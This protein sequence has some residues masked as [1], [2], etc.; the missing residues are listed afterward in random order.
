MNRGDVAA[1]TPIMLLVV[2]ALLDVSPRPNGWGP[3]W[4]VER[5]E[6]SPGGPGR[7]QAPARF[8][9]GAA[10]FAGNGTVAPSVSPA[11]EQKYLSLIHGRHDRAKAALDG[12]GLFAALLVSLTSDD[13]RVAKRSVQLLADFC[14]TMGLTCE[15]GKNPIALELVNCAQWRGGVF[16]EWVEWFEKNGDAIDPEFANRRRQIPK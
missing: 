11:A 5:M 15:R 9:R 8:E 13:E 6:P 12:S 4:P 14:D 10:R 16:T 2:L 7:Y 1:V 3:A